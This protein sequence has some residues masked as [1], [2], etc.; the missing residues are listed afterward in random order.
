MKTDIATGGEIALF[1]YA[2]SLEVAEGV[3]EVV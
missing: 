2:G 3:T 1:D